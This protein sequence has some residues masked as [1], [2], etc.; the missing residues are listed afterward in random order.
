MPSDQHIRRRSFLGLCLGTGAA[1]LWPAPGRSA[2]TPRWSAEPIRVALALGG[3]GDWLRDA[4]AGALLGAAEAARTAEL[5]GRPLEMLEW[6]PPDDAAN[7][8]GWLRDRG[9]MAVVG[10][11]NAA[12]CALLGVAAAHAG[13]AFLN[14]GATDDA[15]RGVGCAPHIFHIAASE[16]MLADALAAWAAGGLATAAPARPGTRSA[17]GSGPDAGGATAEVTPRIVLWHPALG[18]FGAEQ[19]NERFR[20][21][22]GRPMSGP[23][24]AGWIA[25]KI[26]GDAALRARAVRGAELKAHLR[27][28]RAQFDGHKGRALTFRAWDNQLRQPLYAVAAS[29][30]PAEPG[31]LLAEL[32]ALRGGGEDTQTLLDAF[33]A[34]ARDTACRMA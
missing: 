15:L 19:V 28:G 17:S 22:A 4:H 32:P 33:G 1:L 14:I 8:G 34:S 10:G 5:L 24:W 7:A 29:D 12:A 18:R 26:V 27:S 20:E 16:R 9:C 23:A 2:P 31:E 3:G 13:A 21:A 30:S 6:T 11:E 25:L